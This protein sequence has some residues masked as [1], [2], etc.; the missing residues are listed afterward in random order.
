MPVATLPG[1]SRTIIVEPLEAPAVVPSPPPE[2]AVPPEP[3]REREPEPEP[4]AP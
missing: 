1:P 4:A 2:P 3:D